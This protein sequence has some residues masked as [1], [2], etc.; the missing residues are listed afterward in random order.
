MVITFVQQ[1]KRQ[2]YLAYVF[3]VLLVAGLAVIIWQ[4][5][6]AERLTDPV[7]ESEAE[8]APKISIDFGI[9]DNPFLVNLQPF[10]RIS[11]YSSETERES[12]TPIL[13][14]RSVPR[15]AIY[16]WEVMGV[17][18][19]QTVETSVALSKELN[20]STIYIWRVRACNE[21]Q[22]NCSSWSN[23]CQTGMEVECWYFATKD[24][25]PFNLTSPFSRSKN[26]ALNPTLSWQSFSGAAVYFWEVVGA[27]SGETSETSVRLLE[28]LKPSTTYI[29]RVMACD[30]EQSECTPWSSRTF[31]TTFGLSVPTLVGPKVKEL[32]IGRN[33]PFIPYPPEEVIEEEPEE[34]TEGEPEEEVGEEIKE[35]PEE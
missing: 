24:K 25:E 31:T 12:L 32:I 8:K 20:P 9:F 28:N 21:D 19:G 10:E 11:L 30:E 4:L 15:A 1:K 2:K 17:E 29:W 26:R 18:S 35:E 6:L 22:S 14:W 7:E 34:M 23:D 3:G 27:E 16:F 5:F 33:N 13:S